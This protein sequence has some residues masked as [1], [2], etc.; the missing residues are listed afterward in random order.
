MSKLRNMPHL[1]GAL[2]S[3]FAVAMALAATAANANFCFRETYGRGVGTVPQA[4][5]DSDRAM[6]EGLCYKKCPAGF[7]GKA[8][9]CVL[10]C[11]AG[12]RDDGALLCY[13]PAQPAPY[14]VGAGYPWKIGDP[15]GNFDKA[16]DRCRAD[17]GQGCTRDGLIWYPNCKAGFHKSGALICSPDEIKCPAGFKD[18]GVSCEKGVRDRGVGVIPNA[19]GSGKQLDA[20]L[21]YDNCKPNFAGVGPVCGQQ[22]T[23][24]TPVVCGV[25]GCAASQKDCVNAFTKPAVSL[26]SF[27][28]KEFLVD[29]LKLSSQ[30]LTAMKNR[31][32]AAAGRGISELSQTEL[33]D[34]LNLTAVKAGVTFTR[35]EAE[36][37]AK[38][39]MGQDF[40]VLKINPASIKRL[41]DAYRVPQTCRS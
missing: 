27:I 16:G 5:A 8:T 25:V 10:N 37:L 29:P 22:C 28:G 33:I 6:D 17:N 13:K 4:C 3:A 31:I 21:C 35:E 26:M 11:P 9:N 12:F 18:W 24:A 15:V 32:V 40:D 2:L 19:C 41:S 36:A 38:A 14:G 7:D 34:W 30:A 20:G 39:I 23:G 1:W